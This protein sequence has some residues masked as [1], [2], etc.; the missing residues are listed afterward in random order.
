MCN[1][2][3][4]NDIAYRLKFKYDHN[5]PLHINFLFWKHVIKLNQ[6]KKEI[7]KRTKTIVWPEKESEKKMKKDITNHDSKVQEF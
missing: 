6:L 3:L 2:F 7:G 1:F 5:Q 4:E